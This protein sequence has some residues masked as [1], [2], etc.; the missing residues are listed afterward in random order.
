MPKQ[1]EVSNEVEIIRDK[2]R[3]KNYQAA[4]QL[5]Q[6]SESFSLDEALELLPK[7]KVTKFDPT[8]ELHLNLNTTGV[9]GTIV[10]P[11][12]SAKAKK[13]LIINEDNLE[14]EGA[15]IEAGKIDF[16]VLIVRPEIMPKIAKF[17]KVL[18][19]K[20]LMPNPKSGTV[21]DDPKKVSEE[22]SGGRIEYKQD[23]DK[24][25]HLAVGKL[26]FGSDRLKSNITEVLK[27][28]SESKIKS[29][30]L[31]LTMAP[32]ISIQVGKK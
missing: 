22:I 9:R 32:S 27:T 1:E 25:I 26:S 31:N 19:P 8:V 2:S 6:G 14:T 13:V 18:G 17:A 16:D 10:L 29:A 20:G 12:G 11:A 21:S 7:T 23:K 24:I 4:Q 30:F 5:T 28:I 15:K 3:G